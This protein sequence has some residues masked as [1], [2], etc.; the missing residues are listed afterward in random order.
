MDNGTI[1][2]ISRR[3]L[4]SRAANGVGAVAF[5]CLMNELSADDSAKRPVASQAKP[6]ARSV[7]FL[8][9]DGGPS[10][11]DTFDPKPLLDK[12]HGK[13]PASVFKVEPTQFNNNGRILKS[14]WSF[15]QYGNSGLWIS[16]LF[17]HLAKVADELCVVRSM[18]SKFSEHTAA[19]YFLHTG[20]GLQGRPSVGAWFSYGLGS[21]N[22]SLPFFVVL[23]GGLIPVGGIENFGN[24]FLPSQHQGS[25]FFANDPPLHNIKRRESEELQKRKRALLEKFDQRFAERV[26]HADQVESAIQ[27]YETAFRMQTS[28][29]ELADLSKET[30]AT[31]QAYGLEHPMHQTRVFARQCLLAR[32]LVE[33]GVRF[34]ELTCPETSM[35]G[36][37]NMPTCWKAMKQTPKRS[38]NRL[39][40]CLMIYVSVAYLIKRW[41]SSPVNLVERPSRKVPTAVTTIRSVSR[42]GSPVAESSRARCMATLMILVTRRSQANVIFMI[43]MRPCCICLAS[44]IRN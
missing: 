12:H 22:H 44:T 21:E 9:M 36:G 27:N 18:T 8:Y 19:N 7:I 23:N 41:W 1:P 14:P 26:Q 35:I 4:L 38:I 24:G 17:P 37:I 29:P 39:P 20:L 15:K 5:S 25:I 33:R 6:K 16:S 3:A 10:Q 32:R 40:R 11:I 2:T 31:Q 13:E 42:S 43:F 34:I 30:K 28:V